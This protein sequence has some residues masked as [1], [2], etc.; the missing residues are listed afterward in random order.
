VG[1]ARTLNEENVRKWPLKGC[2]CSE[3]CVSR[4]KIERKSSGQKPRNQREKTS[5][6][7]KLWPNVFQNG[8]SADRVITGMTGQQ[9]I[10]EANKQISATVTASTRQAVGASHFS[11]QPTSA[12]RSSSCRAR[13]DLL[14][15]DYIATNNPSSGKLLNQIGCRWI[16]QTQHPPR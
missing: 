2:S 5:C 10:Q 13:A 12:S 9:E 14:D 6:R 3:R 8:A 1:P 15:T 4:S 7:G 11:Q 16:Q